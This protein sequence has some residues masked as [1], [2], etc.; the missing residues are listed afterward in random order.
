MGSEKKRDITSHSEVYLT[1][2]TPWHN[3]ACLGLVFSKALKTYDVLVVE[4][5]QDMH[6]RKRLK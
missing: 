5:A 3:Q 2:D 6:C 4:S 1:D